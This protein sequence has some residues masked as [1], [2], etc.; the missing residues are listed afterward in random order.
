MSTTSASICEAAD[1]LK[2]FVG[3]HAKTGRYRVRFSEDSFGMDV[4]EASIAPTCEFVWRPLDAGT[5]TLARARIQVLLDQRIDEQ[6]DLTEPLRVY[7][8][9]Q[10]LPEI[11]AQRL[12]RPPRPA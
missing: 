4:D 2:G 11:V 3:Y 8:R 9:R 12:P 1:R 7:M 5:M 10:D 6:L